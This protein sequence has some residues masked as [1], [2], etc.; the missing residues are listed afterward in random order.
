MNTP[1]T[2][3][4]LAEKL[5]ISQLP[6]ERQMRILERLGAVI[7]AEITA[8]SVEKMSEADVQE[9]DALIAGNPEGDAVISFLRERVPGFDALAAEVAERYREESVR[10]MNEIQ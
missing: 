1:F 3:E 4:S 9:F 6:P 2:N 8:A 7:F 10:I 5:G